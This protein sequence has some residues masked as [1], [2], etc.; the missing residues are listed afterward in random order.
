MLLNFTVVQSSMTKYTTIYSLVELGLKLTIESK[1]FLKCIFGEH[2]N[3]IISHVSNGY[4]A[5]ASNI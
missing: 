3:N 5:T 4:F 1:I 2:P